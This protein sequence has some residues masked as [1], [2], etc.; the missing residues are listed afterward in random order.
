MWSWVGVLPEAGDQ[1]GQGTLGIPG[2][3]SWPRSAPCWPG[4]AAA[5]SFSPGHPRRHPPAH[6]DSGRE[7]DMDEVIL[8]L[9]TNLLLLLPCL[10]VCLYV[11]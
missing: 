11:L 9:F 8:L 5:P 10:F 6:P 1:G 2:W 3:G 4:P 7:R